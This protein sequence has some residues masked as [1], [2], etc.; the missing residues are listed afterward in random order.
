MVKCPWSHKWIVAQM[1]LGMRLSVSYTVSFHYTITPLG[2]IVRSRNWWLVSCLHVIFWWGESRTVA[3]IINE[4]GTLQILAFITSFCLFWCQDHI[5]ILFSFSVWEGFFF[6]FFA[7]NSLWTSVCLLNFLLCY[8]VKTLFSPLFGF[9]L[10]V[11][12][13]V[14]V[15]GLSRWAHI[16]I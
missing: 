9:I 3:A 12:C 13:S 6:F 5:Q 4:C 14:T 11:L 16:Q 10:C 1:G 8:S 2:H 15:V 7:V